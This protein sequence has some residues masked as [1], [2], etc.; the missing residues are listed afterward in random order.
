MLHY[1]SMAFLLLLALAAIKIDG[2][3]S[4]LLLIIAMFI[5]SPVIVFPQKKIKWIVVGTLILLAMVFFPDIEQYREAFEQSLET[6]P[7]STEEIK[8]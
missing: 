1:Y 7:L 6:L 4:A 5:T 3:A 8:G 2:W